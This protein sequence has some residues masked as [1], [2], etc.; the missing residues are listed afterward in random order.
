MRLSVHLRFAGCSR[1]EPEGFSKSHPEACEMTETPR[2]HLP[3]PPR[4][5]EHIPKYAKDRRNRLS[6]RHCLFEDTFSDQWIQSVLGHNLNRSSEQ[7]LKID[8]ETCRKPGTGNRAR[9]NQEVHI[10]LWPRL[11][12]GNGTEHTNIAGAVLVSDPENLVALCTDQLSG[13]EQLFHLS[14]S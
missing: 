1:L 6:K 12:S 3:R 4:F 14:I 7:I 8:N 13:I 2:C 11:T 10:T 9:V 5:G